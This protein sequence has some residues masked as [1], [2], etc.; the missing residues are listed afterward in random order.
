MSDDME[1]I[2]ISEVSQRNKISSKKLEANGRNAQLSTG[3]KTEAAKKRSRCNAVK[4]GIF[5]EDALQR[6]GLGGEDRKQ[7]HDLLTMLQEDCEPVGV[8]E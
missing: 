7:F 2:E 3:P 5:S 4:L 6:S 8:L 1:V